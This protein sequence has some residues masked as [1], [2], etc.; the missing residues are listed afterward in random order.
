MESQIDAKTS[1]IIVNNPSNPCGSVWSLDHMLK[2]L[3]IAEKYNLPLIADE[4]YAYMVFSHVTF[5]SFG[6]V[7]QTVPV[8]VAGGLAKRWLAPGWRVGWI[9][10]FDKQNQLTQVRKGIKNLSQRILGANTICQAAIPKILNNTTP[11]FYKKVVAVVETNARFLLATV[12]FDMQ[13]H[14][15]TCKK[16]ET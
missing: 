3:K 16:H 12:Q 13:K 6:N 7:S 15:K 4:V 2:I 1:A 10:V 9:L 11:T 14:A 8:L 5:H